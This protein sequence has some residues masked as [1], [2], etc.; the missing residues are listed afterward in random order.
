MSNP[1]G[2]FENIGRGLVFTG[3]RGGGTNGREEE[4]LESGARRQTDVEAQNNGR[5]DHGCKVWVLILLGMLFSILCMVA[6]FLGVWF[7]VLTKKGC[8]WRII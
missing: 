7:G 3:G 8:G 6:G 2:P 5:R 4:S 1:R